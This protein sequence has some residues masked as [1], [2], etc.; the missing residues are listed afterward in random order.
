MT[1]KTDLLVYAGSLLALIVS[2][3]FHRKRRSNSV[4]CQDVHMTILA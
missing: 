4:H 1:E 3:H 2:G